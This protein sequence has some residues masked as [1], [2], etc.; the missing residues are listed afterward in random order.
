MATLTGRSQA[1]DPQLGIVS[2]SF[3]M[4]LTAFP[5]AFPQ[6][7]RLATGLSV[8]DRRFQRQRAE[9]LR[10]FGGA[11]KPQRENGAVA[12]AAFGAKGRM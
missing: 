6:L 2:G 8:S 5:L 10:Q 9:F 11:L 7:A 1:A 12:A 4:A 3:L